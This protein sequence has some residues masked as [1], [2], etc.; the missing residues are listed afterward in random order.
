MTPEKNEAKRQL[1]VGD[2]S[3][4]K[5]FTIAQLTSVMNI[6]GSYFTL[7]VGDVIKIEECN[8][9]G[10]NISVN[11]HLKGDRSLHVPLDEAGDFIIEDL[12]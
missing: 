7:R 9:V 1:S 4:G 12:E 11:G 8:S 5:E 10:F 6:D 2:L 3:K